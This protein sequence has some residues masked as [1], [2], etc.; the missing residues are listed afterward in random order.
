MYADL[1][2]HTTASDGLFTPSELVQ[3][4]WNKGFSAIAVTDHDTVGG[5]EEALQAGEKYK[6]EVIPGIELS[7]LLGEREI[8]IL[9]YFIDRKNEHLQEM[10]ELIVKARKNRAVKMVEKLNS[11]GLQISL[12]RVREIA[13][14]DFIGRPHIARALLEKGYID[15]LKEAFSE[16]YI[17]RGG[18]AYVERFKLNPRE[19]I[20]LVLQ[21]GGIPVLAHPG[22]LSK[23]M[24]VVEQEISDFISYGL[25]GIEVFYSR[26]TGEQVIFYKKIADENGLLVTGGSDCHGD[27]DN[28]LLGTVKLPYEYVK[29]LKGSWKERKG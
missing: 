26:H 12:V 5:L 6:V 23:G 20:K 27:K 24:P 8:H 22:Y 15:T 17:G 29:I 14:G 4:A 25:Q 11:L 28:F 16:E 9:G 1:H 7:T 18:R 10:L 21:A 19:G 3:N 13:G 2:L